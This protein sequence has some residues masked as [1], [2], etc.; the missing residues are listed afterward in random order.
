MTGFPTGTVIPATAANPERAMM[1]LDLLYTEDGKD[2][3]QTY[4]YG[5]EG[6]HYTE[7]SDGTITLVTGDNAE[8]AYGNFNWT[9]GTCV[10]SLPTD[11]SRIG[12][13]EGLKKMEATAAVNPWAGFKF[14][15]IAIAGETAGI[16][17]VVEEYKNSLEFG[18]LGDDWE[19]RYNDFL[20]KLEVAKIDEYMAEMQ[21]QID[22]YATENNLK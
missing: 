12:R 15:T 2:I 22:A 16:K 1:L 6:T 19:A 17:V 9:L 7:N 4:V 3:Y 8:S 10:Y 11:A 18:S 21:K 13:Y 14:D 20:A 5:I